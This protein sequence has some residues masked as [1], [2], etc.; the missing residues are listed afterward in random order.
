MK[1]IVYCYNVNLYKEKPYYKDNFLNIGGAVNSFYEIINF[2]ETV[3]KNEFLPYNQIN[4]SLNNFYEYRFYHYKDWKDI[5][6]L[7]F[8]TQLLNARYIQEEDKNKFESYVLSNFKE[9]AL[10]KLVLPNRGKK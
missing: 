6:Y 10:L 8:L 1:N 5:S 7:V 4:N 2:I 9:D 3:D